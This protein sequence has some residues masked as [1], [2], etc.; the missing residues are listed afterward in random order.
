MIR[1]ITENQTFDVIKHPCVIEVHHQRATSLKDKM[2]SFQHTLAPGTTFTLEARHH[3]DTT[4]KTS[5][6][7]YADVIYDHGHEDVTSLKRLKL[8]HLCKPSVY[9][10][11][12]TTSVFHN[13]TSFGTRSPQEA[14][15]NKKVFSRKR[16]IKMIFCNCFHSIKVTKQLYSQ[17]QHVGRVKSPQNCHY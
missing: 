14:R 4:Q 6:S 15:Q 13:V 7:Y 10:E 8:L 11:F 12:C 9:P 1:L 3:L 16:C 17:K 5:R 2:F